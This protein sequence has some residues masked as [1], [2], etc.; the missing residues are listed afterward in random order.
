MMKRSIKCCLAFSLTF[1]ICSSVSAKDWST[2]FHKAKQKT[3]KLEYHKYSKNFKV[4]GW[5]IA[6][7]VYFG[8][9]KV[10]GEYGV[11]VVFD[12]KSFSWGFNN[13]GIAI[14]KRF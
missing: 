3:T 12:H 9:A 7:G 6:E 1:A 4:R 14:Q 8:H 10:G 2:T 13:R 11:G 5:R